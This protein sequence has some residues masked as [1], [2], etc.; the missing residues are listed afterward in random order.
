MRYKIPILRIIVTLFV[1]VQPA[2]AEAKDR[3]FIYQKKDKEVIFRTCIPGKL[4]NRTSCEGLAW[5]TISYFPREG[6]GDQ[7]YR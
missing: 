7:H 6:G 4:K 1:I 3:K 5:A 2:L